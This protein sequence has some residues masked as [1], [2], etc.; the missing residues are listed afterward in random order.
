MAGQAKKS[1]YGANFEIDTQLMPDANMTPNNARAA[2]PI[3]KPLVR[4][5]VVRPFSFGNAPVESD[6]MTIPVC[7]DQRVGVPDSVVCLAVSTV[8]L[9]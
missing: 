2:A 4:Q 8:R 7:V 5:A 6:F 9:E 1:K 3:H